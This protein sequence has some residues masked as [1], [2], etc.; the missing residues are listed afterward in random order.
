MPSCG[1]ATTSAG[2]W[3]MIDLER[4][5]GEVE[6]NARNAERMIAAAMKGLMTQYRFETMRGP[7]ARILKSVSRAGDIVVL[8]EPISAA[9]RASQHRHR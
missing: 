9:E 4:L 2:G 7:L 6:R 8:L 5:S 3:H 1:R